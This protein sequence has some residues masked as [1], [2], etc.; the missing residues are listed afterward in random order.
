MRKIISLLLVA[1]IL[2]LPIAN[3]TQ[4]ARYFKPSLALLKK[5]R[6]IENRQ[7]AYEPLAKELSQTGQTVYAGIASVAP[8]Y[9]QTPYLYAGITP[10]G[11]DCSGYIAYVHNEAGL[12]L[13]RTSSQ[14]YYNISK[15]VVQPVPGDLVFFEKT[16]A[17]P[18]ITH[19]GIYIGEGKFIHASTSKGVTYGNVNDTYWKDKFVAYKRLDMLT[20]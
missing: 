2:S 19:M 3:D 4:A 12:A 9:L 20:N 5:S 1:L 17:A 16:I 14:G 10:E 11:F 15:K 8:K 13:S 18:G 6:I 7:S